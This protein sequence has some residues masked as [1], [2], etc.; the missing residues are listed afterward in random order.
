VAHRH[1]RQRV[2][3]AR[4]LGD[5]L[6]RHHAVG[7]G[8]V[9]GDHRLAPRLLHVLADRAGQQIGR[10]AGANGMTMRICFS[11]ELALRA[12]QRRGEHRHG[13]ALQEDAA[14]HCR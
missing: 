5:D 10:A 1:G 7:A 14:L 9:V 6:A 12:T 3:V 11:G 8:A 2:A 4:G 13:E